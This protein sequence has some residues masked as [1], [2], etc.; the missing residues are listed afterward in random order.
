MT[1]HTAGNVFLTW[2]DERIG[3]SDVYAQHVNP[4]GVPVWA[5]NG[6]GIATAARGQH[7]AT[8][9]PYKSSSP[10]RFYLSWTDNRSGTERH[11]YLQ[12][13]SSTGVPQW[14]ADG[15]TRTQ[16]ALSGAEA[17]HG[18]V[19][20]TWYAGDDVAATVYRRTPDSD[21]AS[22]G[23]AVSAGSGSIVFE[24]HD[25][26]AGARYGYRLGVV[27]AAG[28][29]FFGEAWVDVPGLGLELALEGLRPNPASGDAVVSFVLPSAAAAR[30]ELLDLSGRRLMMR[31][32]TGLPAGRHL[33]R[34]DAVRPPAGVYFL[35]L[36]QGS[37]SVST[38]AAF[39]R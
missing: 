15:V 17:E 19:R 18:R 22:I 16:L 34:L 39:L 4:S 38:R 36:T 8:I 26:V 9:A 11:V 1:R 10:E 35:R 37:G 2:S 21:W 13:L 29:A 32:L 23:S 20:L 33:L 28:E 12:R 25:V 5:F 14:A 3:Q 30:L 27:E 6:V 7:L 31:D 24:D